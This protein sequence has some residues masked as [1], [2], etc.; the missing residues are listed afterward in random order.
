MADIVQTEENTSIPMGTPVTLAASTQ[1]TQPGANATL[2][3]TNTKDS[4]GVAVPVDV[5]EVAK[6]WFWITDTSGN[7]SVTATFAFVAFW[8]TTFAYIS[9]IFVS[10]GPVKFHTFDVAACGSY[11]GPVLGL[12]VTRK[13]VAAKYDNQQ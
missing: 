7:G 1:M 4:P 13:W 10:I 9:S 6:K 3:V 12:Y 5:T 2:E 8:A 11:L